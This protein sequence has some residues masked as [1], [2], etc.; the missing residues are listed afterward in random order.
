MSRRADKE[1]SSSSRHV[2]SLIDQQLLL[3]KQKTRTTNSSHHLVGRQK[4][5]VTVVK[6]VYRSV[7]HYG[8]FVG[9]SSGTIPADQGSLF[10]HQLIYRRHLRDKSCHIANIIERNH[11]KRTAVNTNEMT[12]RDLNCR[13]RVRSSSK[14]TAPFEFTPSCTRSTSASRQG[15]RLLWCSNGPTKTMG[16]EESSSTGCTVR[17][18]EELT[19]VVHELASP[20]VCVR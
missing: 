11:T 10:V 2:G 16:R 7:V 15:R 9:T 8:S 4:H 18:V 20:S 6:R 14:S 13:R 5:G 1:N 19:S 3:K 12:Y 17:P